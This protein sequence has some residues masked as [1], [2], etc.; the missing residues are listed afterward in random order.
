MS[1]YVVS[2]EVCYDSDTLYSSDLTTNL[3]VFCEI[4]DAVEFVKSYDYLKNECQLSELEV[5][6]LFPD[7][8]TVEDGKLVLSLLSTWKTKS[9]GKA[10]YTLY[11]EEME[12]E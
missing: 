7:F 6:G 3:K 9:G 1:V 5:E 10:Q 11:I 12:L 4:K 8:W 2:K